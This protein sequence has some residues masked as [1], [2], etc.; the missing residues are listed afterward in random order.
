M[1]RLTPEAFGRARSY[2][3]ERARPLERELFRVHFDGGSPGAVLKALEVFRNDDGGFGRALEPDYRAAN[4]SVLATCAA[5]GRIEEL[6]LPPD[7]PFVRGALSFL[8]GT[9][10][11]ELQRWPILPSTGEKEPHAPWWD[12]SDLDRTFAGFRIN[13][14]AEVLA[15]LWR[16]GRAGE[17]RLA[18]GLFPVLRSRLEGLDDLGPSEFEAL[19]HLWQSP[20]DEKGATTFLAEFLRERLPGAVERNPARWTSYGLK[21]LWAVPDPRCPGAIE[22]A[23]VLEVALDYEIRTQAEDGAWD[24]FWS[25]GSAFPDHW[26]VAREEWRGW[27]TLRNLKTLR[28][29]GRLS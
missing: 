11:A 6:E 1:E 16:F 2:L 3:L 29:F 21:P 22:L 13:P 15:C 17:R 7:H 10:E 19:L 18:R 8:L 14:F 27:L 24:P 4:S 12:A 25:W 9:Y 28:A 23:E 26:P 5:L 20:L